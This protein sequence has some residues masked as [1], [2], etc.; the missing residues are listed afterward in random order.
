MNKFRKVFTEFQLNMPKNW[1][2]W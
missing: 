2:F 1:L